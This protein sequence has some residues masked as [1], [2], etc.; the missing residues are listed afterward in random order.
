MGLRLIGG[1][2]TFFLNENEVYSNFDG[3]NTYIGKATNINNTSYSA[4]LG[5]GVDFKLS[6]TLNLNLEPTFKYQINTFNNTTGNFNPFIV[7]V[8]TG[9]RYK[10]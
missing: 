9:I 8:Y 10:F 7:G 4:N 2:S 3:N 6:K 1:F 5:L